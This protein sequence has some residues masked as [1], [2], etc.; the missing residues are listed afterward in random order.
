MSRNEDQ[1][2]AL[3]AHCRRIGERE[4]FAPTLTIAWLQSL[5]C[6]TCADGENP[7]RAKY[8]EVYGRGERQ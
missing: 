3:I 2:A 7:S 6:L 8:C 5:A 4:G 1:R